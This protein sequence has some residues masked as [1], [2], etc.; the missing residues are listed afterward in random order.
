MLDEGEETEEDGL[1]VEGTD[2]EES[3]EDETC[4]EVSSLSVLSA[5][6]VFTLFELSQIPLDAG[7]CCPLAL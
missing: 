7:A 1:G 2:E 6:E 4:V 5:E 3:S